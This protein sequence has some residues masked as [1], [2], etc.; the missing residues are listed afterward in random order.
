MSAFPS[1]IPVKLDDAGRIAVDVPC[2]AC[3]YNLR[4]QPIAAVSGAGGV[5]PECGS[6]IDVSA[7]RDADR[8]DAADPAWR[9]RVGR[10]VRWLHTGAWLSL[11][12][13]LPGVVV[14]AAALWLVTAKEPGRRETW[15]ARGT[16]L[17]ARWAS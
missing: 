6:S 17:S 8:L 3:G 7:R 15:L 9:T 13:L 11:L 14:A 12:G 1:T 10:G 2:P 5:C 16:R 4:M